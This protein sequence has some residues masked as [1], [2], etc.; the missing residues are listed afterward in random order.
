[1]RQISPASA[2]VISQQS[3]INVNTSNNEIMVNQRLMYDRAFRNFHQSMLF[4][5]MRPWISHPGVP[6]D[7]GSSSIAYIA[8][9]APTTTTVLES[10]ESRE[11]KLTSR[12]FTSVVLDSYNSGDI[13]EIDRLIREDCLEGCQIF[14]SSLH[15]VFIGK[16]A[17]FSLWAALSE[18]FPNG[19]FRIISSVLSN[20]DNLKR[21]HTNF[22]F[23]G[24]KIFPLLIDGVPVELQPNNSS[25]FSA[26]EGAKSF[27]L[28]DPI[29]IPSATV[30]ID[31]TR[32]YFQ[33]SMLLEG[34]VIPD[35]VFEGT[36]VLLLTE[37]LKVQQFDFSWFRKG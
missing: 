8:T 3:A 27:L 21:L 35:M 7:Y 24:T 18:A 28:S 26:S 14:F 1:M 19:I 13:D 4:M 12:S 15:H 11:S 17:L 6:P 5:Q 32:P 10:I 25:F 22:A 23:I 16:A 31:H 2:T 34:T 29:A 20:T 30:V 36:I 37:D 33:S 9:P